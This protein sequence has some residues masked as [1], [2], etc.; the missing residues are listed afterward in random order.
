MLPTPT[1][2]FGDLWDAHA[3]SPTPQAV[4][5]DGEGP[6]YKPQLGLFPALSVAQF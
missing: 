1:H 2:V 6:G 3:L 4:F 5:A